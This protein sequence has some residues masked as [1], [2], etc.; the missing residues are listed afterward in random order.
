MMNCS[1]F[2]EIVLKNILQVVKLV[3]ISVKLVINRA[4]R[5]MSIDIVMFNLLLAYRSLI[6]RLLSN[7]D[8]KINDDK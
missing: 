4:K 2:R 1:T 7:Y 6:D 8:K 3:C 5:N